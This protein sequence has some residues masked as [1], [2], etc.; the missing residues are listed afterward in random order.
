MTYQLVLSPEA[1]S[2]LASFSPPIREHIVESL[3]RLAEN[4]LALSRASHFPYPPNC[5]LFRPEPFFH[6]DDRHEFMVLFRYGQDEASL[7]IIG[8]GH[9]LLR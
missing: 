3:R 6:E 8:I 2:D 1:E 4:P 5:Q 9:Y 7:H